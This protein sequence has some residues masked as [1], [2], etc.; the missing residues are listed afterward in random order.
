MAKAGLAFSTNVPFHFNAPEFSGKDGESFDLFNHK[1]KAYLAI[2]D[3]EYINRMEEIEKDQ[4]SPVTDAMFIITD[5]ELDDDD[6]VVKAAVINEDAKL[7][8]RKMH[9]FLT[10]LISGDAAK[11]MQTGLHIT[12]YETYRRLLNRF[13]HRHGRWDASRG[14][15]S[16]TGAQGSSTTTS[17]NGSMRS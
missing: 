4:S 12:G 5:E 15:S 3:E 11:T 7:K 8:S 14:S 13:M 2:M 9:W 6:N 10:S 16:Q 17:L 1:L